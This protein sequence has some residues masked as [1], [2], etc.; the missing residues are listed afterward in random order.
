MIAKYQIE[1]DAKDFIRGMSSSD[2]I[3]D[4]GFSPKTNRVNLIAKKGVLHSPATITD[5]SANL[6]GNIIA[7]AG[8]ANVLGNQKYF[9]TTTGK[10]FTW[11]SS[12]L[13]LRQTD[14]SGSYLNGTT[15]AVQFQLQ[16]FATTSNDVVLLA[17]SDLDTIDA[18]WWTV[19][20]GKTDLQISQRHPL[21]VF[22]KKM[23]IGD[24]SNLHSWDGITVSENVLAL[25]DEQSIVSLGIEPGT[26]YMLIGITEGTNYSN[27]EPQ[28]AKI[29]VWDGFSSKPLRS[30]I[31][32][33]AV[34][35]FYSVG[36]I[37]F[38]TYGTKLGYW[39]G[40]GISFLRTFEN[41][42]RWGGS[43]IY[44]NKIAKID[45]TLYI[46]DGKRILA[47]GEIVAGRK[48][49]YPAYYAGTDIDLLA[50]IGN[51]KLGIGYAT[52]KFDTLDVESIATIT[53][54]DFYS[55][56]INFPRPVIIRSAFVEYASSVA[57]GSTPIRLYIYDEKQNSTE[58]SS[59]ENTTGSAEY[60]RE[61]L[62]LDV[63][64]R[65]MQIY[66][67]LQNVN[68]GIRRIVISYDVAE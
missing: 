9:V 13:T 58:F 36:G 53:G 24:K 60:S 11:K 66:A 48:V 63:K 51:G 32:D 31:V 20:K 6:E 4:G 19:T 10:F 57:D 2:D 18:T 50:D 27:T 14:A 37:L 17:G 39:N 21:L 38:I 47:Y 30:I 26:G 59:F 41:V 67:L 5:K 64:V 3:A 40:N 12:T 52:A 65:T 46:A 44:H 8:D 61:S 45:N 28:I 35:S 25:S 1:L 23:W 62:N 43:L 56:K 68:P 29:L 16:L 54:T 34:N 33:D 15:S 49:F 55:N 7:S 42:V 22:E